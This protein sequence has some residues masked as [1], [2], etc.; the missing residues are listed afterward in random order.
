MS[1]IGCAWISRLALIGNVH[2][3][4]HV[5]FV[6][7]T[8]LHLPVTWLRGQWERG[9]F[10]AGMTWDILWLKN[11]RVTR[12]CWSLLTVPNIA[13]RNE[14]LLFMG[15]P[16]YLGI[17]SL[18]GIYFRAQFAPPP[19]GASAP[20]WAAQFIAF[21]EFTEA[22]KVHSNDDSI[23]RHRLAPFNAYYLT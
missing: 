7:F 20:P 22:A 2:W 4:Q 17:S 5:T 18:H 23:S 12:L 3:Q 15:L 6:T 13:C 1:V 8:P 11:T 21:T 16:T 10:P 14:I 9:Q 19:M